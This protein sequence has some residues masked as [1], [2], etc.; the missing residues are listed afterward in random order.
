[1]ASFDRISSGIS[2]LDKILDS[3]RLGDNVVFQ[4]SDISDY[5]FFV[6]AFVK[7][8]VEEKR[9]IIYMRFAEH[10]P[11]LYEQE[12]LKIYHLDAD[13]GFESFTVKVNEIITREGRGAY[14][15]Y[16]FLSELQSAWASDLMMGNFFSVTCPYLFEMDTVAYFGILRNSHSYETI[17]RIR[18]TTQLLIDVYRSSNELYIHPLKVWQRYSQTM[19][20]PHKYDS[21][22]GLFLPLTDGISASRFY[23]LVAGHGVV[24]SD[25]ALDNWD[26]FFIKAKQDQEAGALKSDTLKKLCKMLMG[27]EPR[28]TD[29]VQKNFTLSDFLHIKQRMIGSGSIGGKATGMLLARKILE[30]SRPDL[31]RHLEPHDSFYI[32]SDVFYT[33]LVQNGWWKIRIKQRTAEGYFSAARE[34]KARILK[35]SFPDII[36]EQFRRM[37]EYFGQNPI[38][39][40]SS[41]LLEDS[42]GNAFAGKYESIFCVNAGNPDERLEAFENAVRRVYASSMDE[43]ALI[44]RKERGLDN[45]DEQMAILVQRVSGSR[46]DRIFMPCAAGVGY[47]YNSYVWNKEIDPK[48]GFIR[49]VMGLGTRAVDRSDSDYPRSVSL[50]KPHLTPISG[51]ND[52][53]RFS[54]RFA[55][56]LSLS[57]NAFMTLPLDKLSAMLPDWY[58]RIMLEHDPEAEKRMEELGIKGEVLYSRCEGII[59]NKEIISYMKDLL[60]TIQENY[61]YPVDIEFTINLDESGQFAFNLL[62]CR[63]L[64]V[65]GL[66]LKVRIPEC[67]KEKLLFSVSGSTMG[68][69]IYLPI[70]TVILVEPKAYYLCPMN[71]KYQAA[72]AIGK[73]TSLLKK[74]DKNILLIGPGRWGTSSPELG[75][76]VKFAEISNIKALCE[77]SYEGAG[78]MPELSF[79]SHFFQDLVETGIF[80]AA[81]FDQ[82]G[83][84]YRPGL[85]S[86]YPEI[87][88]KMLPDEKSIFDIVK[89]YDASSIKLLLLSDTTSEKTVCIEGANNY[90]NA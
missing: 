1:M 2:G 6:E 83:V 56:V 80:Y 66:G 71:T 28:L 33:Y 24:H 11:L 32:G 48:A 27:K 79:G 86:K 8:A 55:D 64:Q 22:N 41:S 12:G 45:N 18:E 84:I 19:F 39:V 26:R 44:Y 81:V 4:L 60:N 53:I 7:Q 59:R 75:V 40:R 90:V 47:S 52:K 74:Q 77:V 73:I 69:S 72:R 61:R 62:Q 87:I 23:S 82:E 14:Y 42:F 16:D 9:N 51:E 85:L 46:F 25:Q 29:L 5:A 70:D 89:V 31:F 3:I 78:Y 10:Q 54:Q 35:G 36:R 15:V 37:L 88:K 63:P 43:S 58:K 76:P 38:I 50:D 17:A 49:L 21:M 20:L 65:R 13:S 34:L 30:N 67:P 57:E 68:G